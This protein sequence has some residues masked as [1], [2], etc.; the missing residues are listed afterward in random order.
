MN[1]II[2]SSLLVTALVY[3]VYRGPFADRKPWNV[4]WLFGVGL[5]IFVYMLGIW[6][7]VLWFRSTDSATT[8]W[9]MLWEQRG[10]AF[11]CG[12][13]SAGIAC[14]S[15]T[16]LSRSNRW[17]VVILATLAGA[18]SGTGAGELIN[19]LGAG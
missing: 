9:S 14:I 5:A 7:E 2:L 15:T 17:L 16:N 10:G 19:L 12:V 11:V 1:Y 3:A 6:S 4:R 13:F 8:L 18:V